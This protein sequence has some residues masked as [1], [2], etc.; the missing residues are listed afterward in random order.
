M[1]PR[2]FNSLPKAVKECS[3]PDSFKRTLDEYIMSL[4]DTPPTPSYVTANNNIILDWAVT[5]SRT[6][7]EELSWDL[8]SNLPKLPKLPKQ[9]NISSTEKDLLHRQRSPSQ[10]KISFADKDPLPPSPA[11]ISRPHLP[12]PS[13]AP[14]SRLHL[15]PP[16]PAPNS[17]PQSHPTNLVLIS[18]I[19]EKNDN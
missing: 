16:S 14:I 7:P 12:P 13:P 8:V 1:G 10:T 2:L 6:L 3:S 17:R 18:M 19:I 5:S 15:P 9:R 11:P 4:P